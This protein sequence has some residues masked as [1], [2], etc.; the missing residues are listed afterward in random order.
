MALVNESVS[1]A[2]TSLVEHPW[3]YVMH[4][5]L[6]IY[7]AS[8]VPQSSIYAS[9]PGWITLHAKARSGA[10]KSQS[11]ATWTS[12]MHWTTAKLRV[13][14]RAAQRLL[15]TRPNWIKAIILCLC[16]RE[17]QGLTICQW[18]L[19]PGAVIQALMRRKPVDTQVPANK[20][21]AFSHVNATLSAP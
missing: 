12:T 19:T 7:W 4:I 9:C 18:P 10:T 16:T 1:A 5:E 6:R 3:A 17:E 14:C 21:H 11:P 2:F 15:L 8:V 20:Q 13:P